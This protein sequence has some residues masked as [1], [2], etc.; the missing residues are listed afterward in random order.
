MIFTIREYGIN[1]VTVDYED[2]SWAIVPLN[3]DLLNTKAA[4][5][6]HI[7]QWGPKAPVSWIG[8]AVIE[9]GT[10]VDTDAAD[11]QSPTATQPEALV[12]W[13]D[14]RRN[15]Y[16]GLD[17]QADAAY[18]ARN[19]NTSLQEAIDTKIAEVKTLIPKTW[20][21]RTRAEYVTWLE[22]LE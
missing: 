18:W 11:Y 14:A 5:A 12:T 15:L 20:E 7:K 3:N 8:N 13:E 4:L 9:A 21:T 16:P 19:G 17:E 22:S 10:Q 6:D 1:T 2:G